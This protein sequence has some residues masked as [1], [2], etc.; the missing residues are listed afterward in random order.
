VVTASTRRSSSR[1]TTASGADDSVDAAIATG[2]SY[3]WSMIP[4]VEPEGRLVRR[5]V[6][7]PDQVRDRLFE[8]ML[9]TSAGGR[10]TPH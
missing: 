7:T 10:R 8:I 3:A 4:R 9:L 6:A 2:S 1:E 5:P